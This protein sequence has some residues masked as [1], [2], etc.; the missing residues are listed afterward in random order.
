MK[1]SLNYI[2][3]CG[4][5]GRQVAAM[6]KQVDPSWPLEFAVEDHFYK[7]SKINDIKINPLS[8]VLEQMRHGGIGFT[9]AIQDSINRERIAIECE[10]AGGDSFSF[11]HP[12]C[13]NQ[14]NNEI[15]AD[16]I[17]IAEFC[18]IMP[19]CKIG[20][21]VHINSFCY[22]GH[23]VTIGDFATLTHHIGLNGGVTIEEHAF[24]GVGATIMPNV[25]IGRHAK[26]GM[27]A[28]ILAD[29]PPNT[30]AVGVWKGCTCEDS[31]VIKGYK[32]CPV[33]QDKTL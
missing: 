11:V 19:N 28:T 18:V 4:G 29:V 8:T 13:S 15:S 22:V 30:T 9:I 26:I 20:R 27:N 10:R 24:I 6:M 1:T 12:S 2:V 17:V 32:Q 7:T 3:G 23:D 14:N 31:E 16:G 33:H 25:R 21:F 5:F